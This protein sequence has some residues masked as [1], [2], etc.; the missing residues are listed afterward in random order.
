MLHHPMHVLI[1]NGFIGQLENLLKY[2]TTD[3]G[4]KYEEINTRI[5]SF[6]Y[7]TIDTHN[8]PNIIEK[9]HILKGLFVQSAGQMQPH[10]SSSIL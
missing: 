10:E 5:S 8:K 7:Y 9:E 2:A 6:E 4:I 1:E 3:R